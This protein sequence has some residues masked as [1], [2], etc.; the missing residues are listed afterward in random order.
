MVEPMSSQNYPSHAVAIVGLAGRFPGA[1]N[2][3][4][5]WRNLRDGVESLETFTDADLDAAGISSA[6]RSNPNFVR[7]GTVLEGADQFDAGFFGISPREAQI[8][9]PQQRIFLECAWEALEHAG[10]AAGHAQKIVGVYAGASMNTYLLTQILANQS[11]IDAVGGYQLMLGSDKDFLCTRVSYKLDLHGPSM[12]IQTACST[13][14]VAVVVACQALNRG[15]CDMA[16]A[17]GVSALFPQRTGYLFQE[18]MILSPDGHCRPFDADARGTRAGDGAGIVVLKRLSDALAD[19]DTIH[20]VIRGAAINNDG[21]DKAGYTAPSVNGQIEV[22]AMAQTL[23]GVDPRSITYIEAHG[24]ATPLGDPIEIAA[25]TQA[26]RASTPDIGFCRL[27]SLKAN[28]GHLDAA[29]G[30]A[31][32]IKAVLALTHREIPPL[33]NF[34]TP[35]PQ[36]DLERSPFVASAQRTDWPSNNGVR[37]AGVSSFGIGGTNAHVVLEEAPP[38]TATKPARNAHLLVLSAKTA[39]ALE[40]M[41]ANLADDLEA[42]AD[43]VLQD[44]EWTLQTGRREFSHRRALVAVDATQAAKALRQPQCAP[45]LTGSHEGERAS[46][47]L[48][49]QRA[50]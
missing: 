25:L 30:V 40:Q 12:T 45:V 39:T 44:V 48:P 34:R 33:V 15:E 37:R 42:R 16:L 47:R 13:S 20:A 27:G 24:T 1:R 35:N 2:L 6:V 18:G 21:A 23:A 26:F 28:L 7:K 8:I 3:D 36:L 14:L 22:I 5:F 43:L 19:R 32:L 41:T 10:Y 17:G 11:F 46:R 9:D 50:R 4:E 49:V 31:G 29:A 38:A